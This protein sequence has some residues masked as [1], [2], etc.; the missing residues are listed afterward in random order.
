M[1]VTVFYETF[2]FKPLLNIL[3]P[4]F[5]TKKLKFYVILNKIH[6]KYVFPNYDK[7]EC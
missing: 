4:F 2:L 5:C 1:Y 3:K 6:Y 7:V